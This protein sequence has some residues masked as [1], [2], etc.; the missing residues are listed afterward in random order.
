MTTLSPQPVYTII[1][2]AYPEHLLEVKQLCEE[3]IEELGL[4]LDFQG[5]HQEMEQMPGKYAL[6]T[7]YLLLGFVAEKPAGCVG[8]RQLAP[9]ICEMKRLYVRPEYR[10]SGLGKGLVRAIIAKG[11][12]L[13]YQ[14]IRLDT[15]ESMSAANNL[16]TTVGFKDI[17]AY[18]HNPLQGARYME[19]QLAG[20]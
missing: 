1:H 5:F 6:P 11:R 14:R 20:S 10:H 7:G 13:K 2:A 15:L 19:M 12:E 17:P 3:Y 8:L 4:S 18:C 9:N 16:Y